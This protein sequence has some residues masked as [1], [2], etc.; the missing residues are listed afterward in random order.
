MNIYL[1]LGF[2]IGGF[3]SIIGMVILANIWK[4]QSEDK[5]YK[6]LQEQISINERIALSHERTEDILRKIL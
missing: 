2:L 1:I 6:A 3:L 4:A 5:Y